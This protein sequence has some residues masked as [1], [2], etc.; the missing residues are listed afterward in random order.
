MG[1]RCLSIDHR[2]TI[3]VGGTAIGRN[4]EI[5]IGHSREG[6]ALLET[7]TETETEIGVEIVEI[8]IVVDLEIGQAEIGRKYA[9]RI[10]ETGR[11]AM[12]EVREVICAARV[13]I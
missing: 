1:P 8:G 9:D 10:L 4:P 13:L 3:G 7:G 12:F 11:E 5:E 2:G 6:E